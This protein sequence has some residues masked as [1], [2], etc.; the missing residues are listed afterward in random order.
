MSGDEGAG[1]IVIEA[2]RTAAVLAVAEDGRLH[3]IA[4]GPGVG[5]HRP[6]LPVA[7]YPLAYPTFGEEVQREPALRVTHGDGVTSTRL[8]FEAVHEQTHE[9]GTTTHVELVDRGGHLGVTLCYRTWPNHDLLEQWVEVSNRGSA[10]LVVHQAAATAPSFA[11]TAPLLT[12]WGGGWAGEWQQT[13]ERLSA[14]TKTVASAGGVRSSLYRPPLVLLAPDGDATETTGPV[15]ACSVAW[16]GDT[17]FDAEV[18]LHGQIRVSA[19]QQW[20]G[21]ERT[22]AAGERYTSASVYWVWSD[23]GVG[24]TSRALHDFAR[25]HVLRGG[26]GI[27]ATV[28][29][30]CEFDGLIW[31]RGD[32]LI[33]PRLGG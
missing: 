5:D 12:H 22:L 6:E 3:Q 32:G 4:F 16:G 31:P 21:A 25:R 11:G 1:V 14:G 23:A 19:G 13:T 15:V 2:G 33:W 9:F 8:R 17:R 7:L 27:R 28:V 24:P 18:A 26:R 20:R 30:T 29:N 10:A